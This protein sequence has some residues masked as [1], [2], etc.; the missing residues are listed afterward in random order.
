MSPS[1]PPT[2]RPLRAVPSQMRGSLRRCTQHIVRR[3][4]KPPGELRPLVVG[5]R[6]TR[7]QATRLGPFIPVTA[8]DITRPQRTPSQVGPRPDSRE[9]IHHPATGERFNNEDLATQSAE[10]DPG[11]RSDGIAGT[12]EYHGRT[13][14]AGGSSP[15]EQRRDRPPPR[16]EPDGESL[17]PHR[18][19]GHHRERHLGGGLYRLGDLRRALQRHELDRRPHAHSGRVRRALNFSA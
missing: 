11:D 19:N 7:N 17:V 4:C 13:R 3:K 16:H 14:A 9:Q 12:P 8:Q 10:D 2:T 5:E 1:G 18:D 15:A 6:T